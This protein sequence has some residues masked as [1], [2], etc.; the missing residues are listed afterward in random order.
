LNRIAARIE[1]GELQQA[2]EEID[3][4]SSLVAL[5]ELAAAGGPVPDHTYAA[6]KFQAQLLVLKVRLLEAR[7][8]A[9]GEVR[10][11]AVA[12]LRKLIALRPELYDIELEEQLRRLNE[13]I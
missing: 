5:E 11:L 3:A 8:V 12:A 10:S 2:E 9:A 6:W 1:A 13:S 4:L 7:R